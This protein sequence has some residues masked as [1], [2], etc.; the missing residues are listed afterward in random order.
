MERVGG[1]PYRLFGRRIKPTKIKR[2]GDGAMAVGDTT[3]NQKSVSAVGG[4]SEKAL[5][6]SGTSGGGCF[7]IVWRRRMRRREIKIKNY[8][9]AVDGRKTT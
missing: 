6:C 4:T 7:A 9:V 1:M 8:V 5:N 2:E 3:T